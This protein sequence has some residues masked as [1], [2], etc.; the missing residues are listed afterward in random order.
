MKKIFYLL[1]VL[2]LFL[3]S[4]SKE[5]EDA[6]SNVDNLVG[7][8]QVSSIYIKYPTS[9]GGPIWVPDS[10]NDY[11]EFYPDYTYK[12][13]NENYNGDIYYS[14]TGTYKFDGYNISFG[15][16]GSGVLMQSV[17]MYVKSFVLE[18]GDNRYSK[19]K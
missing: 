8:W 9:G 5:E 11:I 19:I 1:A 18:I 13:W 15:K 10:R 7:T 16:K 12:K 3:V 4:C 17:G 14:S 6:N 2:P